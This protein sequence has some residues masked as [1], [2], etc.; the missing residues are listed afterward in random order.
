MKIR[1]MPG[2]TAEASL[3]ETREHYTLNV[4]QS[5]TDGRSIIHPQRRKLRD[6]DLEPVP[7]GGGGGRSYPIVCYHFPDTGNTICSV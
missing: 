5:N 4:T 7:T 1:N 6:N 3:G 2:F